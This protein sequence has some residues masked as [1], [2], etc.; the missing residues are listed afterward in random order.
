MPTAPSRTRPGS[1]T[2]TPLTTVLF[3]LA[4]E[5]LLALFVILTLYNLLSRSVDLGVGTEA[6]PCTL[7]VA[8]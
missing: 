6:L 5:V 7:T 8:L 4:I 3:F 2:L 1:T